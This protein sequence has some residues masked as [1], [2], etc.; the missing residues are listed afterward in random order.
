MQLLKRAVELAETP[1]SK[2]GDDRVIAFTKIIGGG[3][4][5]ELSSR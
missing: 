5:T 2:P 1:M 4:T 3:E